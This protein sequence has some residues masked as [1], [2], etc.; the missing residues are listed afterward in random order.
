MSQLSADEAAGGTTSLY[1]ALMMS[2]SGNTK[3]S[4]TIPGVQVTLDGINGDLKLLPCR[5]Q[6]ALDPDSFTSKFAVSLHT[7][8]FI[9][10][11]KKQQ[12]QQQQQK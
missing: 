10:P 9:F 1:F 12:Q 2:F 11:P 7:V 4:G 5:I 6:A 8:Q 3:T